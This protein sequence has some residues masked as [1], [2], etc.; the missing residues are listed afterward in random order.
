MTLKKV[1]SVYIK[2]NGI[3]NPK[4]YI[5]DRIVADSYASVI[6][7]YR[8]TDILLVKFVESIKVI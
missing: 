7:S 2:D 4:G 5:I 6:S 8:D 1:Y 3:T